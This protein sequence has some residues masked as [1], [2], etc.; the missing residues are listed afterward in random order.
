MRPPVEQL[1]SELERHRI[2]LVLKD[3]RLKVRHPYGPG[4]CNAPEEVRPWVRL[5]KARKEELRFYLAE[6]AELWGDP[7]TPEEE[8]RVKRAFARP[9]VTVIYDERTGEMRWLS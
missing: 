5:L 4:F 9:G 7:V 8:A 3:G 2:R 1:V 6:Q